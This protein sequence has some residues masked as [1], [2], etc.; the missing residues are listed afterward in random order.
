[1]GLT[2]QAVELGVHQGTF[3]REIL[4]TWKGQKLHLVDL[5]APVDT[6]NSPRQP[7]L[8]KAK[9]NVA[10]FENRYEFNRNYTFNAVHDYP[11]NFFDWIYLDATHTYYDARR[12]IQMWW[13]KLKKGGENCL[14]VIT[15]ATPINR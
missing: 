11:D 6:Y 9:A 10:P 8:E 3:S 14:Q 1:M 13:P 7:D 2:G 4:S 5:W 12:D 15:L